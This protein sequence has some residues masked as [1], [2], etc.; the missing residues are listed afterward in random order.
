MHGVNSSSLGFP[1][2]I[3]YTKIVQ[4]LCKDLFTF[5][6]KLHEIS[7]FLLIDA[8]KLFCANSEE[9]LVFA[10]F[11]I[12]CYFVIL[13][14]FEKQ[15]QGMMNKFKIKPIRIRVNYTLAS[16]ALTHAGRMSPKSQI[17][18][19]QTVPTISLFTGNQSQVVTDSVIN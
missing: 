2:E 7:M 8:Q 4:Q 3:F 11:I 18:G 12:S 6:V 1:V 15:F 5:R 16:S 13:L 10:Y 9:I 17:L 19:H 14:N